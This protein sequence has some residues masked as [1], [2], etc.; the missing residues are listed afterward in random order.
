M[1]ENSRD[2]DELAEISVATDGNNVRA[3][4]IG[5]ADLA[6]RLRRALAG[7]SRAEIIARARVSD[8]TITR[9]LAG[10]PMRRGTLAS[11]AEAMHVS[12]D[13][14][15]NGEGPMEYLPVGDTTEEGFEVV[16]GPTMPLPTPPDPLRP[17]TLLGSVDMRQM[18]TAIE[19]AEE[20]WK[21]RKQN[22]SNFRKA[23]VFMT[24]YDALSLASPN[25]VREIIHLWDQEDLQKD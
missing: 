5:G 12:I 25:K 10:Y 1:T 16:Q 21:S 2:Y 7:K 9:G 15:V 20:T 8:R 22:P 19:I 3:R 17:Q 24:L 6:N 18:A 23:Q 13:W 14:L 4:E 11:L